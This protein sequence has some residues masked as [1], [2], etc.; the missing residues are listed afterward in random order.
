MWAVTQ[1]HSPR[2]SPVPSHLGCGGGLALNKAKKELFR[3]TL[4]YHI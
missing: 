1:S 2:H 4:T 3:S